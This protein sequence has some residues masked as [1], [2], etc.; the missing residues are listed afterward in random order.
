MMVPEASMHRLIP[1]AALVLTVSGHVRPAA[2]QQRV[3]VAPS[4]E[5][6]DDSAKLKELAARR[7]AEIDKTIAA[8]D[9]P[10]AETLLVAEIERTQKPVDLLKM[11]AGV[12]MN[13][14]KPL[15][16]AIAIK[17]AETYGPLDAD[18]R[19]QLVLA[20]ISM[21]RGDWARPELERLAAADPLNAGYAYWLA[22]LDYDS[23]RYAAAIDRL[24]T[25]VQREPSFMRAYDN[26]GLCYEALN[27]PD[28]AIR[29]YREAIRR[30]REAGGKWPWPFL[31]LGI[32]LKNSGQM[33]EAE[34]LFNEALQAD[35]AFA[36][37]LYHLGTIME[38]SDRTDEAVQTLLRAAAADPSYAEPHFA[39]ARIYRRQGRVAEADAALA[40]F[41]R[42]HQPAREVRQ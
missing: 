24:K 23:G 1:V 21:R 30:A 15:N 22:R 39:L 16:A 31:N 10:R 27:Q 19:M 13:E 6:T 28:E 40:T 25:V 11:L 41:Q 3:P 37:A 26:L 38:G 5:A 4:S 35:T 9:W 42:L 36:P 20:Y 18:T 34:A 29:Q 7:R 17:K 12:F 32:L 33:E 8:R 2:A 14:H